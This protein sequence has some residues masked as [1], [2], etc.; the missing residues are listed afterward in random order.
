MSSYYAKTGNVIFVIL[1]SLIRGT[2]MNLKCMVNPC[3]RLSF[4]L[5]TLLILFFS[6]IIHSEQVG[7]FKSK[8]PLNSSDTTFVNVIDGIVALSGSIPIKG[9]ST[10]GKSNSTSLFFMVD[11]SGSMYNKYPDLPDCPMDPHFNRMKLVSQI[12]DSLVKYSNKYPNIEC[13]L[14]VFG[15]R[16]YYG[17]SNS[18]L[19]KY[20]PGNT[21]GTYL[22]LTELNKNYPEANDKS[23]RDIIKELVDHE[24][25][26]IIKTPK[27]GSVGVALPVGGTANH[28]QF[29][30]L[31][32]HDSTLASIDTILKLK[33]TPYVNNWGTGTNIDNGFKAAVEAMKLSSN[34]PEEQFIIF[35]SD[36]MGDDNDF[37]D[38]FMN[39][40]DDPI[41]TTFTIY[42]TNDSDPPELLVQMA[43][44]IKVNGYSES[45]PKH[46]LVKAYK[47]T[48]IENL[49]GY[50]M[51]SI[52][53]I[54]EAGQTT[55][56]NK[57]VI[58][59]DTSNL[60]DASNGLFTFSHALALTG[61]TT[62][63]PISLDLTI[64]KDSVADDNSIIQVKMDTSF[65]IL[66]KATIDINLK[67]EDA[68]GDIEWWDRNL[69]IRSGFD[70][71]NSIDELDR[72][73]KVSFDFNSLDSDFKYTEA[74]V[75]VKSLKSGDSVMLTCNSVSDTLFENILK[76]DPIGPM[77][78]TDNILTC[79]SLDELV[80]TFRNSEPY[81]FPLDT[82]EK[83][84]QYTLSTDFKMSKGA[85]FDIDA[86]GVCDKVRI[87]FEGN[88][89]LLKN[90]A[91]EIAQNIDLPSSRGLSV[92]S[93]NAEEDYIDIF[94]NSSEG[95]NTSSNNDDRA[96]VFSSTVISTGGVL[97]TAEIDLIDSMAPVI[98][99]AVLYDN[100]LMEEDSLIV[101]F[102]EDIDSYDNESPF[103]FYH[104]NDKYDLKL[105]SKNL[106]KK[107]Q[108]N[109][110]DKNLSKKIKEGDLI[111]I[112]A[113]NIIADNKKVLQKNSE[114]IKVLIEIIRPSTEIEVTEIVFSDPKGCGYP[115]LVKIVNSYSLNDDSKNSFKDLF[116]D[117]LKNIDNRELSVDSSYWE[118]SN[119][120][121]I[122]N[123][124]N[125]NYIKTVVTDD[126]RF[127]R[128]DNFKLSDGVWL[129]SQNILPID[130]MGPVLISAV[131]IDSLATE[132]INYLKMIFSEQINDPGDFNNEAPF[133]F[134]KESNVFPV[135]LSS[136]S[137]YR[138]ELFTIPNDDLSKN[139]WK[140]IDSV[141][142]NPVFKITDGSTIQESYENRLVELKYDVVAPP[143]EFELK[144]S[145]ITSEF[146]ESHIVVKPINELSL[147]SDDEINGTITIV[148]HVGNHVIHDRPLEY[149]KAI[150]KAIL[151][152]DGKNDAGRDVGSGVF[153]VIAD[154]DPVEKDGGNKSSR[155]EIIGSVGVK[156]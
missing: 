117:Y 36:G 92:T 42:F 76:I 41:P 4:I 22:P 70:V 130:S 68:D 111:N 45:N 8:S 40:K 155:Q 11:H 38:G 24:I 77:D 53:S 32:Y 19:L 75:Y 144:T 101:E 1:I 54:F 51:D 84:V 56:P 142:I 97:K 13:G 114:N 87:W 30:T 98:V 57:I 146:P 112:K 20:L 106:D 63:F 131:C 99:K 91:Y 93:A 58:N 43:D 31:W 12:V 49:V 67:E 121:L 50:V 82:L 116:E 10:A 141:R 34:E 25:K 35:L 88:R 147:D 105:G 16:L 18:P 137:F 115:S 71:V 104:D 80:F 64:Y 65:S 60:W 156:Y 52:I 95:V 100:P 129:K 74:K 27:D 23:G 128:D 33:A 149:K 103:N 148:D 78:L 123:Q 150:K 9:D 102:S 29:N 120:I 48:T 46:T 59:N 5:I 55:K 153:P 79:D 136:I 126:D 134:K 151:V 28:F 125:D 66:T 113:D 72:E 143:L 90:G 127:K 85:L 139:Y 152:W 154:I 3:F 122:C 107:K 119:C 94:V 135:N 73:L 17:E 124:A 109:N 81:P 118:N 138:T 6:T 108:K 89:E 145:L 44:S 96:K 132:D 7:I 86:N 2:L 140:N 26:E 61:K 69:S 62:D 110:L 15:T 83:R 14:G 39:G 37:K 21:N 133:L 47:N